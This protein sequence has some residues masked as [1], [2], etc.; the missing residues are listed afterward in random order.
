MTWD[1]EL[2]DGLSRSKLATTSAPAPFRLRTGVGLLFDEQ[3][4]E[5]F[6]REP[7]RKCKGLILGRL[8]KCCVLQLR[9]LKPVRQTDGY[10]RRVLDVWARNQASHPRGSA[11]RSSQVQSKRPRCPAGAPAASCRAPL[12]VLQCA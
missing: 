12:R 3:T 4:V 6:I 10:R 8:P 1:R 7:E 2:Q 9:D 5:F 11:C